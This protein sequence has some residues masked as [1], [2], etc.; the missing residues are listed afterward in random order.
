MDFTLW[1]LAWFAKAFPSVNIQNVT[2]PPFKSNGSHAS[3]IIS[4]CFL[5][6]CIPYKTQKQQLSSNNASIFDS[7]WYDALS[8]SNKNQALESS[9]FTEI[10]H[11]TALRW[12]HLCYYFRIRHAHGLKRMVPRAG[13]ARNIGIFHMVWSRVSPGI[14]LYI[15]H[16]PIQSHVW[17][18]WQWFLGEDTSQEYSILY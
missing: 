4:D 8:K 5:L 9:N 1:N 6:R 7:F 14:S 13:V 15:L 10:C 18:A 2:W 3:L 12:F 17:H 16:I 11:S